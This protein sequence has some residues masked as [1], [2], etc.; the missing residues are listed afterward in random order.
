MVELR[1]EDTGSGISPEHLPHIFEPFFSS[2]GNRGTGLGLAVTWG[3][4]EGHEGIIE[5]QSELGRGTRFAVQLPLAPSVR[6]GPTGH[7][8][9]T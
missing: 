4:I 3:I 5:V 2:K 9:P 8:F 6:I 7:P 1:V